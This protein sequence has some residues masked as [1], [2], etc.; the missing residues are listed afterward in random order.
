MSGVLP[1]RRRLLSTG[2]LGAAAGL[3]GLVLPACSA[4]PADP[5]PAP[6]GMSRERYMQY[7]EWF[8]ANDPRF[9]EYYHPDV[10]LELG[11]STIQGDTA[12][13]DFY[14]EVKAHIHEKVEVTHFISD[15]TGIAAELPTE[16]RVYKDWPEPNYFRRPLKAGEV[17]RVVSFGLYW[18][19]D[20]LF[21]HIKAA[22]YKL[23]ND[24]QMEPLPG[25]G[26]GA[27]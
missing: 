10:V 11:A 18:V 15:A 21:R 22:R 26:Q 19:E 13:R 16:F 4:R 20:G 1:G 5:A 25:A 3:A 12:I 7:V 17:F 24:W 23:V 6:A 8:N 27:G 9:I 2:A 14:A